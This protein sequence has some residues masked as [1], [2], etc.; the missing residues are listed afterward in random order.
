MQVEG[1]NHL[2]ANALEQPSSH[3]SFVHLVNY[4]THEGPAEHVKLTC[5]NPKKQRVASV[6]LYR[7]DLAGPIEVQP[8]THRSLAAFTVP[9][10]KTYVIAAA[11][12]A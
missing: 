6:R 11:E 4:N 12:W 10:V 8:D 1:P 7:P 3:L 5:R 2:I 9:E